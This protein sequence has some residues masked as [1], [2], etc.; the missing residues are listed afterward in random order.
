MI[1]FNERRKLKFREIP[2]NFIKL[3]NILH[4]I[5]LGFLSFPEIGSEKF[6]LFPLGLNVTP[7]TILHRKT[8]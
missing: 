5:C 4:I 3:R 7:I 6:V 2:Q 1:Y 8:V